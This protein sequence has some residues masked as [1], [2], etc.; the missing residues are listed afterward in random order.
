LKSK[1]N[2]FWWKFNLYLVHNDGPSVRRTNRLSLDVERRKELP[3]SIN[4]TKDG[5]GGK[6]GTRWK[7]VLTLFFY[8][9]QIEFFWNFSVLHLHTKHC[10]EIVR[11][12]L[13][14]SSHVSCVKFG[15]WKKN[16]VFIIF[17]HWINFLHS[18]L[19]KMHFSERKRASVF[20]Q[21]SEKLLQ[22]IKISEQLF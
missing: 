18:S 8:F 21:F 16:S 1:T 22:S 20:K 14:P 12:R 17:S 6:N 3:Q 10:K 19:P 5:S 11:L 15:I 9:W 4:N 7:T 13:H 2:N